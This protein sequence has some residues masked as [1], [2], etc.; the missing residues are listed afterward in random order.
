MAW[1]IPV[2]LR[3]LMAH[4][5]AP[6]IMKKMVSL[7]QRTTRF[8]LTFTLAAIGTVAIGMI[9]DQLHHKMVALILGLGF[10]NGLA[11]YCQWRATD[12]SLA[13]TS[14]FTFWDDV[15]ALGLGLAILGESQFFNWKL[16]LGLFIAL[17]SVVAYARHDYLIAKASAESQNHRRRN[18]LRFY[19]YVGAYSVIWGVAIFMF[20]WWGLN[21]VPLVTFMANWYTGA[22]FAA[23]LIFFFYRDSS[24]N[25]QTI[26]PFRLSSFL[27]LGIFT[28]CM[29]ASIALGYA[30]YER[31]PVSVVQPIFLVAEMILPALIGLFGFGERKN[32]CRKEYLL[33]ASAFL[34]GALVG[35]SHVPVP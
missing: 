11:A 21:G 8:L 20:R 33:L 7:P 17:A 15:I 4:I 26:G 18:G 3:I 31:A 30:A 35:L 34:G 2:L 9:T 14:V 22:M 25:Q 6:S 16:A 28:V 1:Y 27:L 32:L 24:V 23:L 13:K 5:C 10:L 19:F 12:I 29:V